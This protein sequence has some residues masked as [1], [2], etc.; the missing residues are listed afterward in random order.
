MDIYASGTNIIFGQVG[1]FLII[2]SFVA[3]IVSAIAYG[4]SSTKND[5]RQWIPLGRMAFLLHSFALFGVI[6][7][8][9][10]MIRS[11]MFEFAYVWRSSNNALP[12]RFLLSSFWE[13]QEGST[14]L[15]MFWLAIIGIILLFRSKE[16]EGPVMIWVALAQAL[17]GSML[18]GIFI[19]GYKMG[20]NPFTLLKDY[21]DAPVFKMNPDFI[22]ED[23]SGLNP[24]LQN[25]W[26]TIH[27]P[28]L[29]LGY[30][31]T[32][33][34]FAYAM[35]SLMRRSYKDW[36]RPVLPW[37]LATVMVLGV[38]ILM[39]GAW[40]YEALSFGG[41]WAWDP[42]ENASLVPWLII[43][44]GLHTLMAYKHSGYS[45][46][47]TYI[48]F[49]GSFLMVLYSSFL[50]KSGILGDSSVHSFTDM[51]M[52][53]Q[54]V[55]MMIVFAVPAIGYLF[56]RR[57]DMPHKPKEERLSSREFWLFIGSAVF[58][59]SSVHITVITSFP[60]INKIFGTKLAPPSDIERM[61]N[62]VQ[63]WIGIILGILLAVGQYLH[64]R[65]TS[66]KM[67]LRHISIPLV[68][69]IV[70]SVL[71][72]INFQLYRIDRLLL[73]FA[74]AFGIVANIYYIFLRLKGKVHLYGASVSHAGFAMMLLGIMISQGKQ[75]VVSYNQFAVDYGEGYSDQEKAENILLYQDEPSVMNGYKITYLGDSIVAEKIFYKVKYEPLDESRKSFVLTPH[76]QLDK[77]MGN[78]ANPS[79]RRTFS[80]DLYTHITGAPIAEEGRI[81]DS[82]QTNTHIMKPGDT[83]R[84]SRS[85][86]ILDKI[87]PSA[88]VPGYELEEEDLAVGAQMRFITLDSTY[89]IEPTYLIQGRIA[90]SV[91]LK[92]E[93]ESTTFAFSKILPESGEVEITTIQ[94]FPRYIIMKAIIFPYINLLWA[95]AIIMSLGVCM[96]MFRRRREK[97]KFDQ[98]LS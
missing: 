3:A 64:Y 84:L 2:L 59:L 17:L 73:T 89:T 26:M 44:A 74:G 35:A 62:D 45:L 4:I 40:A 1:H 63:I 16:W 5:V 15:W 69:S 92:I 60:V 58:I 8:M 30:A 71:L 53:G 19:F 86:A 88:E 81:A 22:P 82:T 52:S 21:M 42:V 95:G 77:Q 56:L 78:V 91:P 20:S 12:M 80:S 66:K 54:L 41:F 72:V 93:E 67:L 18:L 14:L 51:G 70:L 61:F 33:V 98:A 25:Y 38:G 7:L 97:K 65:K 68:L 37:A 94:K 79:T 49:T 32:I 39:G 48:L 50:T 87:N 46:S 43:V 75:E 31:L 13:G 57:R 29:F 24:L 6:F 28:T 76:L 23:G 47:A 85:V 10:F 55:V 36:V 9:L 11:H 83:I 90:R 96:S 34:P 27:P